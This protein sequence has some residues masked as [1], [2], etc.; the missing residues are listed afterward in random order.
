V[1]NDLQNIP[2]FQ[3]QLLD[4]FDRHQRHLPWRSDP[5]PY[6]V[7][8][9]ETMLQQTQVKTVI[10]YFERFLQRFPDLQTLAHAAE[11]EVLIY[12]SGLGYYRRARQLR[13]TAQTITQKFSGR[14]PEPVD[15]LKKLP[16]IGEYTARAISSIAFGN[17]AAVVDGNVKRVLSRIYCIDDELQ[18]TATLKKIQHLAD[19]LLATSRPGDF[20]QA[21][22]ELGATICTTA[23]PACDQCPVASQCQ[24]RARGVERTLPKINRQQITK[25]FS[26]VASLILDSQHRLL[27]IDDPPAP[28]GKS[29]LQ[30]IPVFW[31]LDL[32]A[33]LAAIAHHYG[34]ECQP[35]QSLG[36]ISHSITSHRMSI[37]P[38]IVSGIVK[39]EKVADPRKHWRPLASL[40]QQPLSGFTLKA[41]R[42]AQLV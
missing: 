40:M 36:K 34:I 20:N 25:K 29:G 41:L 18:K 5:T 24:A 13:L 39:T 26:G 27:L 9:S 19:Q 16:G 11:N 15:E 21:M 14:F 8:V 32:P 30:D 12:W 37:E 2:K 4:W 1:N 31:D 23:N 17:I 35:L 42:Q 7:L 6:K 38:W 3:Q 22:M 28:L 10:P 33:M